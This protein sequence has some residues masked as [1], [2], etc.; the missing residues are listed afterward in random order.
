ML[1]HQFFLKVKNSDKNLFFSSLIIHIFSFNI[2]HAL[3]NVYAGFRFL[4]NQFH[5]LSVFFNQQC[6]FKKEH[7]A[8]LIYRFYYKLKIK[9]MNSVKKYTLDIFFL[10]DNQL[11]DVFYRFELCKIL[12]EIFRLLLYQVK[13]QNTETCHLFTNFFNLTEAADVYRHSHLLN[14]HGERFTIF[15]VSKIQYFN[16]IHISKSL[17]DFKYFLH[18]H[19]LQLF[20]SKGI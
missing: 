14:P 7:K 12:N 5:Q 3:K 10:C 2:K 9:K 11:N 4:W 16:F 8:S 19:L 1:F 17:P 15:V 18:F 13:N 20:F 6:F